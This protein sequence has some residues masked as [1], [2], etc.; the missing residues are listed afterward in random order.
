MDIRQEVGSIG[1]VALWSGR[2]ERGRRNDTGG[3]EEGIEEKMR[4]K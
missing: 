3:V 2:G 4:E 1:R